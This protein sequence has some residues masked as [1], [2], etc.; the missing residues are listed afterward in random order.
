MAPRPVQEPRALFEALPGRILR[1]VDPEGLGP[2]VAAGPR[3]RILA[4]MDELCVPVQTVCYE[5]RLRAG[6]PRVDIAVCLFT[7][8]TSSPGDVLGRLGACR[9]A[10]ASWSR[11]L[12]FLAEW[13][14]PSSPFAHRIPFVCVAFDL[15]GDPAALPAPGLSLCVDPG[16][17]SR[18]LGL[19]SPPPPSAAELADL[20][21]ACHRRLHGAAL[22]AACRGMLER[23]LS[24]DDG[25]L[26]RHVSFMVSRTP[27]TFKL[28]LRL[29]VDG[30]ASLLRRIGWPGDVPQVCTRI[31]E[32]MPWPG[33]VQLNLVLHPALG[34]S[35]EVEL[36]TG[37]AP[38][39]AGDRLALLQKL[40]DIGQCDPDKAQ[41]LRDAW[42][43]PVR[44]DDTGL[45]VARSWYLKVRFDGD[46]VAE[47]KA[48]LG[49]MP[50]VL[51]DARQAAALLAGAP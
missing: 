50:R 37:R 35:L 16:F 24:G 39:R 7:T 27:S 5:C 43:R 1:S 11:S 48:Y 29:P 21:D 13:S 32:L 34:T 42:A 25:V 19:P 26:A 10:D 36:L 30:V 45:I 31:R 40:V 23:C 38:C 15:P 33:D 2:L 8:R 49:F 4:V 17:F 51:C 6:D 44:R 22:P 28:D 18:Q 41:V 46:R 12:A 14:C 3:A 47:T 20:S 9:E